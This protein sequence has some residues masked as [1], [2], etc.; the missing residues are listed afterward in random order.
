[1]LDLGC[2]D[3]TFAGLAAGAGA[4]S[5][6]AADVAEAA[7][8][9]A[10][11]RFPQL[12]SRWC[13]STGHCRSTT[14][15]FEL[16]WSSE[17]IEHVA[18]TASWLSEVR[19]VLVPGGRLLLTTPDHG[20][21]RLLLGG[22]ERYS[23]PLGDHLHLYTARSLS[24]AA[25]RVRVRPGSGARRPAGR[26][27]R[28]GCCSPA[29][30]AETPFKHCVTRSLAD[31][32]TAKIS[33]VLR[34][35]R[36]R[37]AR[38]AVIAACFAAIVSGVAPSAADAFA[39]AIWGQI[40]RN[41]VNQF[42]LYHQL[43]VRIFQMDLDWSQVAPTRP[44]DPTNPADPAYEW[45]ADVQQALT[46]AAPYHMR[47]LLQLINAPAWA[48]GGHSGP[49]WAPRNPADFAAFAQAAAREYPGVH[50]WM[51]WGEPT[52]TGNFVPEP[53]VAARRARSTPRRRPRRTCTRGCST[54]PTARSRPSA[55]ATS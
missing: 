4:A 55:G 13:R 48:D 39:K 14:A 31:R 7:L 15:A 54:P 32:L 41:G 1:M 42:P 33:R 29:Q 37:A 3:G 22:I 45:P 34:A 16:V 47:V 27:C 46:D 19:R 9:R 11:A 20:R 52:K 30:P 38:T 51:I 10:A 28:G 23:E 6:V 40:T 24:G 35:I 12:D 44:A 43:G 21:L 18:D 25:E 36:T 17:V 8:A 26:R 5:V 53:A 50:L 49:G 2:G